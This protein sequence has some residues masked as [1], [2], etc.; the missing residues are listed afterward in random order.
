[1]KCVCKKWSHI[2]HW[3]LKLKVLSY[4]LCGLGPEGVGFQTSHLGSSSV[5]DWA[6]TQPVNLRGN[7]T[8][9]PPGRSLLWVFQQ[10]SYS[11]PILSPQAALALQGH[12]V[13]GQ[14]GKHIPQPW[15]FS[16]SPGFETQHLKQPLKMSLT[17]HPTDISGSRLD[18]SL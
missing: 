5:S 8:S 12:V 13:H 18:V 6:A 1:M 10:L 15:H 4:P 9:L 3:N 7:C 16:C 2:E 14:R 11:I 17:F